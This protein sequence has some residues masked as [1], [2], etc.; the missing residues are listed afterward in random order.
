MKNIKAPYSFFSLLLIYLIMAYTSFYYYPKWQKAQAEATIGWDVA[1]YYNYLPALFIYKDLKQLSYESKIM[2]QYEPNPGGLQAYEHPESGNKVIKYSAGMAVMYSPAFFVADFWAKNSKQ[3]PADGYSLPYQF[4]LSIWSLCFA[5][6]GLFVLRKLL[7]RYF[8]DAA[9][10]LALLSIALA[11]N[12]LAYAAISNAMSHNYL[13]S[14]YALMLWN[15]M[16]FQQKPSYFRA[17]TI[18]LLAGLIALIR[19]TDIVIIL[20]P[21]LWGLDISKKSAWIKHLNYLKTELPK[22]GLAIFFCILIGSIQLLYWKYVTNH[23]IYYSYNEGFRWLKPF[24]KEAWFSYKAGWLIYSPIFLIVFIGFFSL[25][26]TKAELWAASFA[27]FLIYSYLVVSWE[28]WWYGG[29]LGLRAM[30]QSYAILA[31]PIA[32]FWSMVLKQKWTAILATIF[33]LLNVYYN[34]W[35]TH[36]AHK[37]GLLL[38]AQMNANYFWAILGRY[39][40]EEDVYKLLD[41]DEIFRSKIKVQQ[42]IW[43]DNLETDSLPI[44][45]IAPIEGH[46]SLFINKEQQ[47]SPILQIPIKNSSKG[48]WIRVEASYKIQLKEWTFWKMPQLILKL[49]K[50][51]QKIKERAIRL[52]R[53]MYDHQERRIYMDIQCP[54]AI[55]RLEIQYWNAEGDKI[56]LIDQIQV[57]EIRG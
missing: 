17:V 6:L 31:I 32:S 11:S 30:V 52:T 12:Y 57:Y 28:N 45:P 7:I 34:L 56:L 44:P 5:F 2:E 55:D 36:Q 41:T 22:I 40:V 43:S 53:F 10:A 19:P 54:S 49:K 21:L 20:V 26:K 27:F 9:T 14:L 37:G 39:E 46:K 51:D 18:G 48:S 1:G 4:L 15:S 8:S 42:L 3:Y 25:W 33:L 38:P 35:L 50:E 29:G 13:F 16:H 24:L 23:W 47:F